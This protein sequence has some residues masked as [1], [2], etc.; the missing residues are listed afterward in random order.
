VDL[1]S[2][3]AIISILSTA[4]VATYALFSARK[5]AEQGIRRVASVSG[6]ALRKARKEE[7]EYRS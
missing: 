1:A 7:T 6:E 3:V 2:L 5:T 4:G